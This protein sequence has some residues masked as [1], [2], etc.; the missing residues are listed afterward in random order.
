MKKWR[1]RNTKFDKIFYQK[2][3]KSERTKIETRINKGFGGLFFL[4]NACKY[5]ILTFEHEKLRLYYK[6]IWLNKN[7]SVNIGTSVR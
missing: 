5:L 2:K 7:I 4:E 6:K 3:R 1:A